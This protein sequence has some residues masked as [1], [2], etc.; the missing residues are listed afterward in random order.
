MIPFFE[1]VHK[2]IKQNE[3]L[4][5][6]GLDPD[7]KSMP[8]MVKKHENPLLSFNQMM[9][10]VTCDLVCCYKVN[11]ASYLREG[12]SGFQTLIDTIQYA[13]KCDVPVI[14]DGKWN[15]SGNM[16]SAYAQMAFE[17]LGVE[18]V[19][20]NPYLGEDGIS[21]FRKYKEKGV[22]VICFTSNLSRIDMQ[23]VPVSL[24]NEPEFPLYLITAQQIVKWNKNGNLGVVVG[25]T[26]P[27][28]L[29]GIR[30]CV[31]SEI[32]ILCI[33][34]GIQ[35]GDLEEILWAGSAKEGKLII[36][37]SKAIIHASNG[38]NFAEMARC[39]A[40]MFVDQMQTYFTQVREEI[41]SG[42]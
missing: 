29:A 8:D 30:D 28:E 25:I 31:G 39:E 38:D 1:H 37:I 40:K 35:G 24:P 33:G 42:V 26:T 6:I 3:S 9:I 27:E 22:F 11:M 12:I 34:V 4:L 41:D 7:P 36:N 2:K 15:E 21:P 20:L 18:A 17:L 14:L 19:T 5:S 23:M 10:D 16:A 13:K 32:P